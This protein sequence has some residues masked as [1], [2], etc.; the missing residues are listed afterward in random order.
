[1]ELLNVRRRFAQ[2]VGLVSVLLLGGLQLG[3]QSNSARVVITSVPQWGQDGL[4]TGYFSGPASDSVRLYVLEFIPDLGW[5]SIPNCG[6]VAI[7]ST[8][9]F[10]AE[11]APG[12]MGR[13]ATRFTLMLYQHRSVMSLVSVVREASR[14]GFNRMRSALFPYPGLPSTTPYHLVA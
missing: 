2:T 12:I 8:G 13:Y 3:S 9:E 4:I 10:S 1:M 5:H 6:A 11:T 14:F 7:R